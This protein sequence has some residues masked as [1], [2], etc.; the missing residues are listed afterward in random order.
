VATATSDSYAVQLGAFGKKSNAQAYKD[1][2]AEKLGRKIEIVV[3]N[4]LY[5]VRILDFESREEVDE[6]TPELEEIGIKEMWVINLKGVQRQMLLMT[7]RDTITEVIEIRTE[8]PQKII[9][10]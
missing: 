7:V 8:I 4:G 6:F 1:R 9:Q 10:S 5:K 2:L 3:E